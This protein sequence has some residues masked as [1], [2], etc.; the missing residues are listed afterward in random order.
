M[1]T[2]TVNFSLSANLQSLPS[3]DQSITWGRFAPSA[4]T[5]PEA[6]ITIYDP[7]NYVVFTQQP[8]VVN[9]K[10]PT[11]TVSNVP[12]GFQVTI[13]MVGDENT[14]STVAQIPDLTPLTLS[15]YAA[16]VPTALTSTRLWNIQ[17]TQTGGTSQTAVALTGW[18]PYNS[19]PLADPTTDPSTAVLVLIVNNSQIPAN[20]TVSP[21]G[22]SRSSFDVYG[23][24]AFPLSL[25]AVYQYVAAS[26][27][28]VF[29]VTFTDVSNNT[30]SVF[31]VSP[32]ASTSSIQT[33]F[34]TS[35]TPFL[36]ATV[37]GAPSSWPSLFVS[38]NVISFD[39]TTQTPP[40]PPAPPKPKPQPSP[41]PGPQPGSGPQP[42]PQPGSGPGPQPR[43]QPQPQPKSDPGFFNT[44][45]K[46]GLIHVI[47]LIAIVVIVLG[48]VIGVSV[49]FQRKNA[50][51]K[52]SSP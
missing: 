23:V 38:Q 5:V 9:P 14:N 50:G 31:N 24:P 41:Q 47:L 32:T 11:A 3:Q 42:G 6:N 52:K 2:T 8:I 29:T 34:P 10:S 51:V 30:Q 18:G 45:S 44:T 19:T 49:Y 43:P 46:N 17:V 7:Q 16:S 26:D 27:A 36:T 12:L 22:V 1:A 39:S 15:T 48:V 33:F 37:T 25:G 4:G 21:A 13:T 40:V 20:V 28:T 35:G